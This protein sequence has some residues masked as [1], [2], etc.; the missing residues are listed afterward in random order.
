MSDTPEILPR[1]DYPEDQNVT[2]E[3]NAQLD[4]R[5]IIQFFEATPDYVDNNRNNAL[6]CRWIESR[7]AS[8]SLRNLQVAYRELSKQKALDEKP[9]YTFDNPQYTPQPV[10]K[11]AGIKRFKSTVILR[12]PIGNE[13]QRQLVGEKPERLEE[14]MGD[15]IRAY[16]AELDRVQKLSTPGAPV[17]D[18]LKR[19]AR[20]S[21]LS[22]RKIQGGITPAQM[23]AIRVK[24]MT[25]NPS[26][27]LYSAEFRAKVAEQILQDRE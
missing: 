8:Y 11:Y 2:P 7:G 23:T 21:R 19:E 17:S 20:Q 16:E 18:E 13:A 26:L 27:D 24:V 14:L 22:Q 3:I 9:E 4:Q 15:D 10:D 5:G 6:M 25:E 1:L 12:N